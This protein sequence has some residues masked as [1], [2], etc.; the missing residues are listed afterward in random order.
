MFGTIG[1]PELLLI[2]LVAL[3]IFG[4]KRLPDLGRSLGKGL[5]EFRRASEEARDALMGVA[6]P[7]PRSGRSEPSD[8]EGEVVD[9]SIEPEPPEPPDRPAG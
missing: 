4:P 7:P 8:P 5:G 2:L 3:I 1:V 6:D 9:A